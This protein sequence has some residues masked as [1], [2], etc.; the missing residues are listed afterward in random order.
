M[1]EHAASGAPLLDPTTAD[2]ATAN[3]NTVCRQ[4]SY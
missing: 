1:E 2:T 4:N 3:S